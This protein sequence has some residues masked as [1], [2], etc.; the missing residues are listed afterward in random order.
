MNHGL[1]AV[2]LNIKCTQ[3]DASA[4]IDKLWQFLK[5]YDLIRFCL[6]HKTGWFSEAMLDTLRLRVAV[7]FVS[8]FPEPG[9]EDLFKSIQ[10]EFERSEKIQI[11]KETVKPSPVKHREAT[12]GKIINKIA[13][14]I[15]FNILGS[16][17]SAS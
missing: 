10:E 16:L 1:L 8:V 5:L 11:Q 2:G 6:Q 13:C 7:R 17:V 15:S 14:F 12:K 3:S 4:P 9:F